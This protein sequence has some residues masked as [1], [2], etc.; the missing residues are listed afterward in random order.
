M[1]TL[2][3][4]VL[5]LAGGRLLAAEQKPPS[6]NAPVLVPATDLLLSQVR[7]DGKLTAAQAKFTVDIDAEA[8]E[9]HRAE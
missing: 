2:K 8:H 1:R 9:S 6:T 7:Y 3:F 4:L 5:L